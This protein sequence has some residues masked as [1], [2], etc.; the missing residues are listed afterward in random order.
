[1]WWLTKTKFHFWIV[2]WFVSLN[3]AV[4]LLEVIF[5]LF[6]GLLLTIFQF[7]LWL[8]FKFFHALVLFFELYMQPILPPS[9]LRLGPWLVDPWICF[10][11]RIDIKIRRVQHACC[12]LYPYVYVCI[13]CMH[14]YVYCMHSV[15]PKPF[16]TRYLLP[17]SQCVK[18]TFPF[19]SRNYH[20]KKK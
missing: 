14:I 19:W 3:I 6:D 13:M 1:M 20:F 18:S 15:C 7:Y 11:V 12:M 10:C 9:N 17:G 8:I 4:V 16:S 2:F 5:I